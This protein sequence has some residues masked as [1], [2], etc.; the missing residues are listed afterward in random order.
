MIL[1]C[2]GRSG[3]DRVGTQSGLFVLVMESLAVTTEYTCIHTQPK[4]RYLDSAV[5]SLSTDETH[6][7]IEALRTRG[8]AIDFFH[9]QCLE[10]SK[11][12]NWLRDAA[13][14][15]GIGTL[16]LE[17]KTDYQQRLTKNS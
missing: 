6:P 11:E 1:V 17:K 14:S 16:G 13:L 9:G 4:W 7:Q 15:R 3:L 5:V 10:C 8:T 12:I 2:R